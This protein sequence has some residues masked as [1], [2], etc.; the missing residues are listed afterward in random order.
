MYSQKIISN[1]IFILHK[2]K[3]VILF[4]VIL[5][6]VIFISKVKYDHNDQ[7]NYFDKNTQIHCFQ[8]SFGQKHLTHM[9]FYVNCTSL[10]SN[11]STFCI[12]DV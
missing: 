3:C 10:I 6:L 9:S 4:I 7:N 1:E 2:I 11:N 5:F 12:Y 8:R